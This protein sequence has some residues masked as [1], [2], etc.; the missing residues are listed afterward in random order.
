M[1]WYVGSN[2]SNLDALKYQPVLVR[3]LILGG[4]MCASCASCRETLLHVHSAWG[5]LICH[6]PC[7]YLGTTYASVLYSSPHPP[8][9]ITHPVQTYS[10]YIMDRAFPIGLCS[11]PKIFNALADFIAWVLH[12]HGIAH[13]L[14]Y[15]DDFLFLEPPPPPPPPTQTRQ[16]EPW[17]LS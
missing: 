16:P 14:H 7:A 2:V 11:A 3:H 1:G 5:V 4:G 8:P 6:C 10:K 17:R 12:Q 15:P 13:Q 9:V